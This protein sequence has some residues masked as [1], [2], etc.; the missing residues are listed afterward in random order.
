MI[1]RDLYDTLNWYD[2]GSYTEM[3][4]TSLNVYY[5]DED[6]SKRIIVHKDLS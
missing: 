6:E 5:M 1:S 4:A 3:T 2:Y